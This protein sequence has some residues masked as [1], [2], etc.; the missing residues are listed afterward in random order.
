M[1]ETGYVV[2]IPL[3]LQP[4][5]DGLAGRG[6]GLAEAIEKL[7]RDP[8][9]SGAYKLVGRLRDRACGLHMKRD[10]RLVFTF[11][12]DATD[13]EGKGREVIAVLAIGRKQHDRKASLPATIELAH[14]ILGEELVPGTLQRTPCCE[15]RRPEMSEE[16]VQ[17]AMRVLRRLLRRR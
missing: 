14:D 5:V 3:A 16:A 4:V 13:D 7:Q 17:E 11:L 10:F 6:A 9:G 15:E 2:K 8:C 12:P 1:T